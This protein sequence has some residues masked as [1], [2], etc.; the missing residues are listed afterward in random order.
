MI[1]AL[2]HTTCG[3]NAYS[4]NILL[5]EVENEEEAFGEMRRFL[6]VNNIYSDLTYVKMVE[7]HEYLGRIIPKHKEV[8]MYQGCSEYDAYKVKAATFGIYYNRHPEFKQLG[9]PEDW[10]LC[11]ERDRQT[12]EIH[13]VKDEKHRFRYFSIESGEWYN[14]VKR[15]FNDLATRKAGG[16]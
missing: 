11:E 13:L 3:S 12:G 7:E 15:Y 8:G 16:D 10:G 6:Q 5:C 4:A 2:E 1:V 9:I 14:C